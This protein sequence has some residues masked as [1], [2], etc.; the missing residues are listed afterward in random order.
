MAYPSVSQPF[1]GRGALENT[2]VGKHLI[3]KSKFILLALIVD[4]VIFFWGGYFKN[5][6][7]ALVVLGAVVGN[8]WLIHIQRPSGLSGLQVGMEEKDAR[9]S[10][11]ISHE[12]M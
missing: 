9:R 7:G 4:N 11:S 8:H 10:Y 3:L 1:E 6:Q 5:S 2:M 12:T